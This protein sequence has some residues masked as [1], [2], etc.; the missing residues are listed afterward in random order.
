MF[1]AGCGSGYPVTQVLGRSFRVT[2]LDFA[3]EQ[4]LMAKG[5][6]PGAEF[7][8]G[9]IADLPVRDCVFDAIC[10]YYAI[11]HVPR[12]EHSKL[13]RDFHRILKPGGL[14]LLC[15]GAGDLPEDVDDWYGTQMYWSHYDKKTNLSMMKEGGFDILWFKIVDDPIDTHASH[16]FVLAQKK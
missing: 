13:L 14:A 2:G 8:L 15:M 7:I 6:V 12:S 1:D 9:D 11:I 3:K 10:S 4:V 5:T 16:L